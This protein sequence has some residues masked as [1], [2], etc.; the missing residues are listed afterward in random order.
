MPFDGVS[1]EM[2]DA[3]RHIDIPFRFFVS[4]LGVDDN[5]E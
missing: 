4:T 5:S 2:I 1:S 3:I